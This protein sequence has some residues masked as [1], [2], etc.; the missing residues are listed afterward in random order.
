[1]SLTSVFCI[2]G[3]LVFPYTTLFRSARSL[4]LLQASDED[5]RPVIPGRAHLDDHV[6]GI[7][8][9]DG[10]AGGCG[11]RL[12]LDELP[13]EE[14]VGAL[15][16][17]PLSLFAVGAVGQRQRRIQLHGLARLVGHP[18]GDLVGVLLALGP[19]V[20][21]V[22]ASPDP[23]VLGDLDLDPV[24]VGDLL[25]DLGRVVR[26]PLLGVLGATGLRLS[27]LA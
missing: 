4:S 6:V 24:G 26:L 15:P 7:L 10:E 13:V 12:A 20:D 25:A 2:V 27:L 19:V 22:L 5:R 14:G 8:L 18:V 11:L 23:L 21:L 9:R 17:D 3:S 16:V 1:F